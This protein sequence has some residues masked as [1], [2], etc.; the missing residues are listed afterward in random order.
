VR[1]AAMT[2]RLLGTFPRWTAGSAPPGGESL[3]T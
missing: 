1:K 3:L 2:Y